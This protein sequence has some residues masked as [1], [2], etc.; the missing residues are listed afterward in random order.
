[1]YVVGRGGLLEP[2]LWPDKEAQ[3]PELTKS[4]GGI[5]FVA[6]YDAHFDRITDDC[7]VDLKTLRGPA[8]EVCAQTSYA[9][10]WATQANAATNLSNPPNLNNIPKS[11][12]CPPPPPLINVPHALSPWTHG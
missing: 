2:H 10:V 3:A 4:L 7:L 1:M 6:C 11:Y 12:Y 9:A 8:G 5:P